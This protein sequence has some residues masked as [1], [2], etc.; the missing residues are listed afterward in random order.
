MVASVSSNSAATDPTVTLGTPLT[1]PAG[2]YTFWFD[3]LLNYY[4]GSPS[5]G[6]FYNNGLLSNGYTMVYQ[7]NYSAITTQAS[8]QLAVAANKNV[9]IGTASPSQA[10]EIASGSVKISNNGAGSF[11]R[12]HNPNHGRHGYAQ[13]DWRHH[14]HGRGHY[15]QQRGAGHQGRRGT[16]SG[17]LKAN[18]S[19]TVSAAT[20]GTDYLAPNGS[21]AAL[22]NF[23]TLNQNTSGTA[24]NVTGVVA[25]VN[26]AQALPRP[27]VRAT[28]CSASR[29]PW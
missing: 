11:P 26:G 24:S 19:G 14:Q 20:A 6:S 16:V 22:T 21:A 27:R 7:V 15:L 17:I 8:T 25:V 4:I 2:T 12:W 29:R 23:P 5:N 28:P 10:L 3:N 18:G 13:P 9:G 1:L